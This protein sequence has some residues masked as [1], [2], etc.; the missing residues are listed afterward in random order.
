[1]MQIKKYIESVIQDKL[2]NFELSKKSLILG[3]AVKISESFSSNQWDHSTL[4]SVTT[5]PT[6]PAPGAIKNP[7]TVQSWSRNRNYRWW[8][9]I[10]AN[11][12]TRVFIG[13]VRLTGAESPGTTMSTETFN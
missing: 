8:S 3:R 2:H 10:I 13:A 6:R 12:S 9:N 11:P 1:M 4:P 5:S 7:K